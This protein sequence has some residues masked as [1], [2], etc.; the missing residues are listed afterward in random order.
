MPRRIFTVTGMSLFEASVTAALTIEANS[1]DFHGRAEPPPRRVTFGTGQP[2]FMSMW[3][4]RSS[5][6]SIRTAAPVV[7]G[8]TE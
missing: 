3:S 8:S 4:Q 5:S 6:T 1:S 2:K 7:T